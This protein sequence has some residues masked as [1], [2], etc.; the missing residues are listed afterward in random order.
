MEIDLTEDKGGSLRKS[1]NELGIT[2]EELARLAMTEVYSVQKPEFLRVGT[3]V[4]KRTE[5][6]Y[7]RVT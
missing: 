4:L 1:A 5:G 7:R 2:L 6:L 3:R